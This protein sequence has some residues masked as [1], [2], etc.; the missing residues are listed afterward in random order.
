M[1]IRLTENHSADEVP[2]LINVNS[3]TYIIPH[4]SLNSTI[5]Y[6]NNRNPLVV[7]ETVIQVEHEINNALERIS[8]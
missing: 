2:V 4:A 3:I 5:V 8:K 1:F 7:K 6:L